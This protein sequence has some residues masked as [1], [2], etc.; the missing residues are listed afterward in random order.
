MLSNRSRSRWN[1]LLAGLARRQTR[2]C[3]FH[4]SPAF[5]ARR[6]WHGR[7]PRP[8]VGPTRPVSSDNASCMNNAFTACFR[9]PSCKE[10]SRDSMGKVSTCSG[11][12][13]KEGCGVEGGRGIGVRMSAGQATCMCKKCR[14]PE[15][16]S[17]DVE[18]STQK[19]SVG[20]KPAAAQ[21]GLGGSVLAHHT[22]RNSWCGFCAW[23]R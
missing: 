3:L 9:I 1:L 20:S 15:N 6:S 17:G 18:P 11:F 23:C 4:K 12:C 19:T 5:S 16:D 7:S 2:L 8:A 22:Q 10:G 14:G 13:G 21:K